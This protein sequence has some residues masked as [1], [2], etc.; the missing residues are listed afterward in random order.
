MTEGTVCAVCG[1][2][3]TAQET[4]STLPHTEGDWIVDT[5]AQPGTDGSRHTECTICG[6]T[7]QTECIPA[8]PIQET[9]PSQNSGMIDKI[10]DKV[11]QGCGSSIGLGTVGMMLMLA[12]GCML[13]K[14]KKED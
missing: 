14:K 7:I 12:A 8:P 3:L 6:E 5:E 9:E 13:I 4:V 11:S 2:T 1:E 10:K